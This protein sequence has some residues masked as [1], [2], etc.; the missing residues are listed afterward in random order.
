[1][2][3]DLLDWQYSLYGDN[4][5]TRA[6]LIV[7]VLTV[8]LFQLGTLAILASPLVALT[9]GVIAGATQAASGLV[10]MAVVMAIQGRMHRGEAKPPVPFD[11]PVDV[12]SRIFAEQWITFPRFVLRGGLTRAWREAR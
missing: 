1:M 8:P 5:T 2:R 12:L 6:N 10:T 7:H 4:H 9:G 11:G 3:P